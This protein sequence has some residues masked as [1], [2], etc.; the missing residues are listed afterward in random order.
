MLYYIYY[1]NKLHTDIIW[2]YNNIIRDFFYTISMDRIRARFQLGTFSLQSMELTNNIIVKYIDL[3]QH[4][5]LCSKNN[6]YA[7]RTFI[8]A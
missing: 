6:G 8:Y 4:I 3:I 5:I 7:S 1:A 2:G